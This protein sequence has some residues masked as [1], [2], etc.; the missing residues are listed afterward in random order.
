MSESGEGDGL[1]IPSVKVDTSK[2][3]G[4]FGILWRLECKKIGNTNEEEP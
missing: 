4:M 1:P 2:F 3:E